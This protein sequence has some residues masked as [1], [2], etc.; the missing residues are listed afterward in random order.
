MKT[1]FDYMDEC[2]APQPDEARPADTARILALVRQKAGLPGAPARQEDAPQPAAGQTRARPARRLWAVAAAAA[3]AVCLGCAGATAAGVF[4]WQAI[5][6][7]FGANARQ[8]A[9]SLGMPGEGLGLSQ[10]KA[11]ITVTLE[12]ALDDGD[13][14]YVPAQLTFDDG[15][16]DPGLVYALMTSLRPTKPVEGWTSS[17]SCIQL[18]DPDPADNTIP[19]M[20]TATH[21]GV[22]AGDT[23]ELQ[24][25]AAYGRMEGDNGFTTAPWR[26][27]HTLSFSFALP[28]S[29]PA[30]TVQ[31]PAGT[32][33]PG[34]GVP[35]AQV[36]LTPLRVS[37]VF[38]GHPED[39]AVRDALSR[40]PV[41]LTLADGTVLALTDSWADAARAAGGASGGN[42][43]IDGPYYQVSVTFGR[44]LD[45]AEVR[46]VTVSGVEIP[47]A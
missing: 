23:V 4:P 15:Q 8:Q 30:V 10:S 18:E 6:D 17:G 40:V 33:E 5:G 3:L 20:L 25:L 21:Q 38:Q 13:M 28:E 37:V 1:W 46:S 9:A 36:R 19:L 42:S 44:L 26:W 22:G 41:S 47:V 31:P 12:G 27:E 43:P 7:F 39:S 24:V 29:Q 45:P 16:Y 14:L 35:I 11:G 2:Y 34:T 32:A